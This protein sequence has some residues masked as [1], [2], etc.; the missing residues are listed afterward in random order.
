MSLP[1]SMCYAL[2][3]P[4]TGT[5][6]SNKYMVLSVTLSMCM[7][8]ISTCMLH[9]FTQMSLSVYAGREVPQRL[10]SRLDHCQVEPIPAFFVGPAICMSF[11]YICLL[12]TH[13]MMLQYL[14]Y[15]TILHCCKEFCP[16]CRLSGLETAAS[17]A[18]C[19]PVAGLSVVI[20]LQIGCLLEHSGVCKA[21]D[22]HYTGVY[23]FFA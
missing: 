3:S 4:Y 23:A 5:T 13:L 6:H 19:M 16:G 12:L 7:H 10:W 21:Q 14:M 11:V 18:P 8:S 20:H 1:C 15:N 9:R 17:P 2:T 22:C